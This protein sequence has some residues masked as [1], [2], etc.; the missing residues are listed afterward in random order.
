M[1]GDKVS[2]ISAFILN[3]T[4]TEIVTAAIWPTN[5][6]NDAGTNYINLLTTRSDYILE[7]DLIDESGVLIN[8]ASYKPF[9]SGL[10]NLD[11]MGLLVGKYDNEF[12]EDTIVI[13]RADENASIPFSIRYRETYGGINGP[14]VY[15]GP[16]YV[17]V[18]AAKQLGDIEGANMAPYVAMNDNSLTEAE[19]GKFLSVANRPTY[20]PGYPFELDVI[21]EDKDTGSNY[22]RHEEQ[23]DESIASLANNNTTI[24]AITSRRVQRL[25]IFGGY[26]AD[27]DYVD[28]WIES[29]ETGD[30]CTKLAGLQPSAVWIFSQFQTDPTTNEFLGVSVV[31]N[32]NSGITSIDTYPIGTLSDSGGAIDTVEYNANTGLYESTNGPNIL[33]DGIIY[34]VVINSI[35]VSIGGTSCSSNFDQ[36]YTVVGNPNVVPVASNLA[37]TSPSTPIKVDD[38]V[39]L[40]F[41]Y[42]DVD[43]DPMDLALTAGSISYADDALGTN[44]TLITNLTLDGATTTGDGTKL[45]QGVTIPSGAAKKVLIFDVTPKASTGLATGL[46]V[47]YVL[48]NLVVPNT[49]AVSLET[50]KFGTGFSITVNAKSGAPFIISYPGGDDYK[51]G[52]A[53]D[54]VYCLNDR[55]GKWSQYY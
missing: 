28:V 32:P 12:D 25:N 21:I 55:R 36:S 9:S 31:A 7:I 10:I 40:Q 34:Q 27:A 53:A 51:E 13:S 50:N 26:L 45:F 47:S 22:D 20:W 46:T 5:I 38:T 37:V 54:S 23:F 17:G 29:D 15:D 3:G 35:S 49:V 39:V 14:L 52:S 4:D 19:K 8:S 43:L 33:L 1:Y 6:A 41:D 44:K 2:T 30:P 48:P 24:T 42:S 16:I 11:V 18:S